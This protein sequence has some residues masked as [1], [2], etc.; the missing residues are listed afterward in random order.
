MLAVERATKLAGHEER[1]ARGGGLAGQ[2][3]V[4]EALDRERAEER[5]VGAAAD[6]SADDAQARLGGGASGTMGEVGQP[7][8]IDV[9]SDHQRQ[10]GVG[11]HGARRGQVAQVA[12]HQLG[13][14]ADAVAGRVEVAS[15]DH[16]VDRAG[17]DG[18][19]ARRRE[20]GAIAAGTFREG[21]G[22]V[23]EGLHHAT[24]DLFFGQ[25]RDRAVRQTREGAHDFQSVEAAG[26]SFN[27]ARFQPLKHA[28]AAMHVS[29][30]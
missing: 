12:V 27:Q 13:A 17:A 18:A 30:P 24:D 26:A 8:R 23:G 29:R 3:A 11:G 10:Q 16:R 21:R 5:T 9:R 6:I 4:G 22:G 2:D 15:Q 28:W 20:V 19:A 25:L 1:V 7:R 14:G